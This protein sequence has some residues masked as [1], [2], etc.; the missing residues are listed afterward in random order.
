MARETPVVIDKKFL[1]SLIT[2]Y[3]AT[4]IGWLTWLSMQSINLDKATLVNANNITKIAE[5]QQQAGEFLRASNLMIADLNKAQN[6]LRVKIAE[7]Q[8][9]N[10]R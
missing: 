7:Q 9:I 5:A 3:I 4:S 1:L 6:E 8:W 10:R 2:L